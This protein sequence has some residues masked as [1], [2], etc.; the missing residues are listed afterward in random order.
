MSYRQHILY[1]RKKQ[2]KLA[3]VLAFKTAQIGLANY[4]KKGRCDLS[5]REDAAQN[6][7]MADVMFIIVFPL[8]RPMLIQRHKFSLCMVFF[9][10]SSM[11]EHLSKSIKT[12]IKDLNEHCKMLY[13]Y[14]RL[15]DQD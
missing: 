1:R 6:I 8:L 12:G 7:I 15:A 13:E 14:F 5:Q 9:I 4:G 3:M 2:K 10:L 11:L